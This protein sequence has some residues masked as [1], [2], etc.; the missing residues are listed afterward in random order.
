MRVES[1]DFSEDGL[2]LRVS[3]SQDVLH[4][5]TEQLEEMQAVSVRDMAWQSGTSRYGKKQGGPA[6][7]SASGLINSDFTPT[8]AL[9][10]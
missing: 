10:W 8:R 2:V 7:P 6:Q 1:I 4:L 5:T 9:R 3:S